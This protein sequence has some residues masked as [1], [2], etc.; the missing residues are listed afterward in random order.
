MVTSA[1]SAFGSTLSWNAVA[2]AELSSIS[3]PSLSVDT[4]DVS[5]DG[6]PSGFR[7]FIAGMKDGG[8]VSVAGNFISGDTTGQIALTT[9]MMAG[10]VRQVVITDPTLSASTWTFNAI[11]TKFEPDRPFDGKFGFTATFKVTGV[12]VLAVTESADITDMTFEDSVGAVTPVPGPFAGGTYTYSAT[13]NTASTYIKV[14]VTDATAASIK[15][16]CLG[17]EH[18]LTST[19]QSGQITV[20]A[21]DTVTKLT[22]TVKDTGKVAKTY[23]IYITR[24]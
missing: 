1:V 2:L 18:V 17:V 12:P 23:T 20:G 5:S 19:V 24:P 14:T 3:G 11:C 4:I 9:D 7:E 21:A 15:A 10:T 8:E 16:T 22:I 13:I 6:S